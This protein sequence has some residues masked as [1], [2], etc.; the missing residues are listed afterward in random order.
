MME[1]PT[2]CWLL[3]AKFH[4]DQCEGYYDAFSALRAVSTYSWQIAMV[5]TG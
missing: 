2:L 5:K 1:D 3:Y 4:L